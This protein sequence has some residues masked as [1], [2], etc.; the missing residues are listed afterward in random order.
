M[1]KEQLIALGVSEELAVKIAGESKKELEGYVEKSK[2]TELEA[3]KTQL[4]ESQ[5]TLSKQLEDLKKSTGDSK[6]LQ[7]QITKLQ[8]E[9]AVQTEKFKKELADLKLNNAVDM[10][11][12]GAKAKNNKAVKALL[13]TE[14]IKLKDDGT[15]EGVSEQIEALKKSDAYLFEVEKAAPTPNRG[16]IPGSSAQAGNIGTSKTLGEAIAAALNK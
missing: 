15:L 8:A 3:E 7:E 12:A 2:Y 6:E 14:K 4:T 9:N 16:Y 10:A 1:T 5:K 13:N 11:I